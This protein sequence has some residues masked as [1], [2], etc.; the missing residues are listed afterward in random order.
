[1]VVSPAIIFVVGILWFV[2]DG[3]DR[4]KITRRSLLR[5]AL[6]AMNYAPPEVNALKGW[7]REKRNC[8]SI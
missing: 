2:F 1:M 7:E 8:A 3:G 4:F 5:T 6:V